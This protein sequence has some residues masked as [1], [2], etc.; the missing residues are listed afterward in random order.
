MQHLVYSARGI[1]FCLLL[2]Q[3]ALAQANQAPA[4]AP[5]AVQANSEADRAW[6]ALL[7]SSQPPREP[8]IWQTERPSKE[9]IEKFKTS[10]VARLGKA[11]ALA[12]DFQ[13]RFA[14]DTRVNQARA[15][16]YELLQGAVQLGSTNG[17]ARLDS[18]DEIKLKE[19]TSDDERFQIRASAVDRRAMSKLSESR[20]AAFAELEK[21]ARALRKE[22]PDRPEVYDMLLTVARESESRQLA[23]ELTAASVPEEVREN[24][25]TLLNK[26]NRMGKPLTIK[27]TAVDGRQVDLTKL[28]GKVVLIDFWAT[29]CGPCVQELPN[30]RSA[31]EKLHEKGFEIVGISFDKD[32]D[33][34]QSFVKQEK[35]PWPQYFD[36]KQWDNEY[37]KQFDIQSIP[38]M[39]LVDKKGNLRN[40]SAQ[41]ELVQKV[42]QLLAEPL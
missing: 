3:A 28:R 16:E 37:G 29:W 42:E 2:V 6:D 34:L 7:Q 9:E 40:L 33:K 22:F 26:I 41:Q 11:A 24:A 10:E 31:Y 30:V 12:Q 14:G 13:N 38:T 35:M 5:A 1:A 15:T 36:G 39:W 4:A 25:K 21:G 27:F 23:Q 18:L 8:E 32:K 19:A 20:A 17:L